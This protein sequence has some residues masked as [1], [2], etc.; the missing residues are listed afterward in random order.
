MK[1]TPE[2]STLY[3][4]VQGNAT[5]GGREQSGKFYERECPRGS[6]SPDCSYPDEEPDGRQTFT[7]TIESKGPWTFFAP[8]NAAFD[9]A[10][11]L[12]A[13]LLAGWEDGRNELFLDNL[14]DT[15]YYHLVRPP[16]IQNIHDCTFISEIACL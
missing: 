11:A 4:I 14:F 8:D 16:A 5:R 12:K 7:G 10:P 6:R 13:S 9:K 2:L 1:N 3:R 15:L